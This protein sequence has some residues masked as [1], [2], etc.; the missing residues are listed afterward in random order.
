MSWTLS[1]KPIADG[2]RFYDA[3]ELFYDQII[4]ISSG[5]GVFYDG[6]GA[7]EQWTLTNK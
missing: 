6:T 1:N 2:S 3:S 7:S 4:E 5:N